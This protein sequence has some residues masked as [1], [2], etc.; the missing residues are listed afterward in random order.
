MYRLTL[1]ASWVAQPGELPA[2]QCIESIFAGGTGWSSKDIKDELSISRDSSIRDDQQSDEGEDR[3]PRHR[4]FHRRTHSVGS[5]RSRTT[6]TGK[7][8]SRHKYSRSRESRGSLDSHRHGSSTEGLDRAGFQGAYEVDEFEV[9]E[10]LR[11]WK[12][13][14]YEN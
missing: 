7:N 11:A 9:R 14:R 13:P 2:D 6:I 3:T 1:A 10:D 8:K 12:L 4:E 5:S